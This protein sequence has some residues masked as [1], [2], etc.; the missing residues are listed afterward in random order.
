LPQRLRALVAVQKPSVEQLRA[1]RDFFPKNDVPMDELPWDDEVENVAD[2]VA[3]LLRESAAHA[4]VLMSQVPPPPQRS[5]YE[6][7]CAAVQF[8]KECEKER[9]QARLSKIKK[10]VPAASTSTK[11]E[12]HRPPPPEQSASSSSSV[13]PP[14]VEMPPPRAHVHRTPP[15][16]VQPKYPY[17]CAACRVG[18][19]EAAAYVMHAGFHMPPYERRCRFCLQDFVDG[20]AFIGHAMMDHPKVVAQRKQ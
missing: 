12:S 8:H 20:A 6:Q 14:P 13:A 11:P 17:S 3:E 9:E 1:A 16:P 10:S 5:R 15:R 19:G 7:H 4:A 2:S 18:F